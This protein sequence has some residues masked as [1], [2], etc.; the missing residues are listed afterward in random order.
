MDKT[1]KNEGALF[2]SSSTRVCQLNSAYKDVGIFRKS[3]GS[4]L[5]WQSLLHSKLMSSKSNKNISSLSLSC[6]I[7][8]FA[9]E[10]KWPPARALPIFASFSDKSVFHGTKRLGV[11]TVTCSFWEGGGIKNYSWC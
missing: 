5:C 4:D 11:D 10:G 1:L 8:L 6:D 2:F 7:I 9:S 3:E